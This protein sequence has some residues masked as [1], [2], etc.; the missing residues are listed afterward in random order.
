MKD[1]YL[2]SELAINESK[3]DI[4]ETELQCIDELLKRCG[5][6]G[7]IRTLKLALKEVLKSREAGDVL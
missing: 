7:G 6:R 4:L 2:M 1:K 3:V 5:F